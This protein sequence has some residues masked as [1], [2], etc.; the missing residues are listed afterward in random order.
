MPI[1]TLP[2]CEACNYTY[3]NTSHVETSYNGCPC[4]YC[5]YADDID[6]TNEV[7]SY[8]FSKTEVCI[9]NDF[10][11]DTYEEIYRIR[12]T[13][14]SGQNINGIDRIESVSE[15]ET[16]SEIKVHFNNMKL[17]NEDVKRIKEILNK[18]CA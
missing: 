5:M 15:L 10:D 7:H 12:C 3:V 11:I 6:D 1:I 8:N 18:I 14:T 9:D 13:V 4:S 2:I 17:E 16:L